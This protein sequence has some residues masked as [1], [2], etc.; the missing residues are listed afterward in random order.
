MDRLRIN[1][2][3]YKLLTDAVDY[4]ELARGFAS[5]KKGAPLMFDARFFSY[6]I[7]GRSARNRKTFWKC[8]VYRNTRCQA[9]VT[10]IGHKIIKFLG[11]HNHKAF[12][13]KGDAEIAYMF[14]DQ[15]TSEL[16]SSDPKD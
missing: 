9:R 8:S 12:E 1:L 13:R 6:V 15:A 14:K 16:A 5:T 3:H 2:F 10:A 4:L 11:E 7:N